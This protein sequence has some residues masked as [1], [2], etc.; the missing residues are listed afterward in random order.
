MNNAEA[1]KDKYLYERMHEQILSPP[2]IK[3]KWFLSKK[4]NITVDQC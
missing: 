3:I 4:Q 2:N 1:A